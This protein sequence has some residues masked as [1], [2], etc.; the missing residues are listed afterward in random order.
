MSSDPNTHMYS[1][2]SV[3]S[4]SNTGD[5]APKV[6][7]ASTSTRKAPGG[8]KETRRT[9]RDSEKGIEKMAIGHHLGK[10]YRFLIGVCTVF[11]KRVVEEDAI[12]SF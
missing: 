1:S 12:G 9:V 2:S 7:Q 6:Y 5:G 10:D 11:T 4:Y 8:V 3:M